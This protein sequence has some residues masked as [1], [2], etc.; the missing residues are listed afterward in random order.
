MTKPLIYLAGPGVFR[1]DA[2]MYGANLK[3]MARA[4]GMEGLWP[5]DAEVTTPSPLQIAHA[6]RKANVGL[7][8]RCNGV[9]ADISPFRGPNMDAGTAYEIGFAD[10]IGKPIWAYSSDLRSLLD[11]SKYLIT[12][13]TT[14]H[15]IWRD[16]E[17]LS[18]ENLGLTENLM[19]SCSVKGIYRS[20]QEAMLA[21][22]GEL[23][24]QQRK[25]L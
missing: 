2:E 25:A 7:I 9:I 5:L 14:D 13:T 8:E 21:A 10:A 22:A 3:R 18:I 4:F 11:R 20:A 24:G 1:S 19:I 12:T 6:V 17:G 23:L 16:A 15:E